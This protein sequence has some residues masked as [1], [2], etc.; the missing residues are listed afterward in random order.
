MSLFIG[1]LSRDVK[2]EELQD[3]F[4]HYGSC[5]VSHRGPYGFV[6][7]DKEADADAAKNELGGK[8]FI[9]LCNQY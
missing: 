6:E 7:Y 1:N 2:T 4:A 5:K 8:R 3:A 9:R